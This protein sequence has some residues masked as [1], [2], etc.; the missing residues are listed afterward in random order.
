MD[1]PTY[2][3]EE[4]SFMNGPQVNIQIHTLSEYTE[5]TK[6]IYTYTKYTKWICTYTKCTKWMYQIGI[7]IKYTKIIG[8][9]LNI[10]F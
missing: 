10:I 2:P 3:F 8:V 4:T 6:W 9:F 1:P 7:P 5:Y